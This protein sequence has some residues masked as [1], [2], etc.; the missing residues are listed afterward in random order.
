MGC[1]CAKQTDEYHGWECEI[2]EGSCM[3]LIPDSKACAREY[4]EGPDAGEW[5]EED[6]GSAQSA[7]EE[8]WDKLQCYIEC[9]GYDWTYERLKNDYQKYYLKGFYC[10]HTLMDI[11]KQ[12]EEEC[13]L[14]FGTSDI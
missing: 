1:K 2:T 8:A 9:H 3:F 5:P 10:S 7:A 12:N 6:D 11:I 4:G 13:R 14:L